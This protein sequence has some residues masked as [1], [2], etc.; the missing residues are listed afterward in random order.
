MNIKTRGN[1]R[2]TLEQ[3]KHRIEIEF[4]HLN[5]KVIATEYR[6]IEDPLQVECL[7][8]HHQFG[9]YLNGL[10]INRG[11]GNCQK[12][13]LEQV[14]HRIEIEYS[15]LNLKLIATEY[16]KSK[17][18][19]QVECLICHHQFGYYIGNLLQN[20]GCKKC[21]SI[22][23]GLNMRKNFEEAK[24]EIE[25]YN[26]KLID[27]Q[28]EKH[29]K[30]AFYK[31]QCSQLHICIKSMSDIKRGDRCPEC[32]SYY[33][34]ER[35]CKKYMEYLF[36][37]PF[38]KIRFDWLI[39]NEGNRMELDGYNDSLKLG[40]EYDGMQ[41]FEFVKRFHKTEEFFRKRQQDDLIKNNLC[42]QHN[43]MLI[44][45]PYTVKFDK[46]LD[47]IK[48]L[49]IINHIQ[50]EDKPNISTEDLDVFN[51]MVEEK[52]SLV[53]DRLKQSIWIR[54]TNIISSQE[55]VDV[56][57]VRCHHIQKILHGNLMK[58]RK[59]PDCNYCFKEQKT[60]ELQNI[61]IYRNWLLTG[62]F[63]HY[64]QRVPMICVECGYND[65]CIPKD[66]MYN[67]TIKNCPK[68]PKN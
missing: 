52:N 16:V 11:C 64:K 20:Q 60:E 65:S 53:D 32:I 63:I 21:T 46:M 18:P 25:K 28:Y 26:F 58:T 3:V 55:N 24:L 35:I 34:S 50:F 38:N 42:K 62:T 29:N 36:D 43:I 13:T 12:L 14:K 66:I 51:T 30:R 45:V 49:C 19:L 56:E 33:K 27:I 31:I 68:C 9:Y 54:K 40:F 5:L 39:N 47:Y 48:Q 44:R 15:H 2:L 4:S 57:C 59:L 7:I 61:V 23:V 1:P 8:C 37:V 22:I 41:H 10:Y 17:D 6:R 67:K